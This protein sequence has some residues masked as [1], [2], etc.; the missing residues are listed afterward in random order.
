MIVVYVV[1][2]LLVVS[3]AWIFAMIAQL[4]AG[5]PQVAQAWAARQGG[6]DRLTEYEVDRPAPSW[7]SGTQ[8]LQ[9]YLIVVLSTTCSA[10]TRI[11]AELADDSRLM[12]SIPSI[13]MVIVSP[14]TERSV[15]F[16]RANRLAEFEP[17]ID[18]NG[19]WCREELGI[20]ESP[21]L[22]VVRGGVVAEAFMFNRPA[23]IEQALELL[24]ETV[25]GHSHA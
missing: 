18:E 1:L 3:V 24:P 14:T 2:A 15:E 21:T 4:A 19:K 9:D 11:A 25:L 6:L 20:A 23:D 22:F 16:A 17:L 10:C 13:R 7:P 12:D 8:P 5:L